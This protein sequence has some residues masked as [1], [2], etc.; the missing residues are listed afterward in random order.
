MQTPGSGFVFLLPPESYVNGE[1]ELALSTSGRNG[2]ISG[3][4]EAM[5]DL[6]A[7]HSPQSK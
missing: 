4:S 5:F 6:V 7:N 2:T 3:V 1:C